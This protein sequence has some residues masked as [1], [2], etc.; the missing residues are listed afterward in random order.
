L[1]SQTLIVLSEILIA[2]IL[3]AV[4]ASEQAVGLA[5]LLMRTLTTR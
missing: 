4:T 5:A 3:V 2:F 1:T